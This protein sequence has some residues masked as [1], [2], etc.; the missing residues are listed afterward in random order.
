MVDSVAEGLGEY[1]GA[2]CRIRGSTRSSPRNAKPNPIGALSPKMVESERGVV[3][4]ERSTG[5]ENS[6]WR[7]LFEN[8]Q[9]TAFPEG[10]YHWPVIGYE[11]DIK[12]WTKEDLEYYFKTYYAPN[13]C[14]VVVS[15]NVKVV[16]VKK[17][18]EKSSFKKI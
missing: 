3:L 17:L 1:S 16:E 13:N 7:L 6:P 5:L 8:V 14:V 10:P 2:F 12:N 11:Q 18:A 15:G 9:A 4:S